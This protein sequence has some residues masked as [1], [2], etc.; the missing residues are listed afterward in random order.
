[1]TLYSI[2][3]KKAL[4]WKLEDPDIILALPVTNSPWANYIKFSGP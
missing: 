3:K 4:G 2:K 1:M